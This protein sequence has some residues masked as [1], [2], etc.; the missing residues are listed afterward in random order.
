MTILASRSA[1][2]ASYL[3]LTALL[4]GT[5]ARP[6]NASQLS[7]QAP[8]PSPTPADLVLDGGRVQLTGEQ[9]F[10]RLVLRNRARVEIQPYS[11]SEQTGLL[12]I[13]ADSVSIDRTSAIVGDAAGYRGQAR[14]EG[15]GPGGGEGGLDSFDGGGGGAHGGA[16]GAGVLDGVGQPAARG[17]RAYGSDCSRDIERGSAGGAPGAADSPGDPGR[18]GHGG[19]GLAIL[20]D[21]VAISGTIQLDG[22]DGIVE[23]NDAGGGGA[24]GGLWIEARQLVFDGRVEANGGAGGVTD[25]GGGGGG[26][27]RVKIFYV[28]GSVERRGI[29][30]NGGRGDGNGYPNDGRRGSLCVEQ[31]TPTPTPLVSATPSVTASPTPRATSTPSATPTASARPSGTPTPSPTASPTPTATAS[32]TAEPRALYL[33]LLLRERCPKIEAAR[34]EIVLVI[35]ASTSMRGMTRGG[36]SKLRAAL[37]AASLPISMVGGR[38]RLALVSFN[39]EARVLSPLSA[40]REQL[41]TALETILSQPGSRLD[42]GIREAVRVLSSALPGSE[43]RIVALTD[44]LPSPSTPEDVRAAAREARSNGIRIDT[45]GLGPDVDAELLQDLAGDPARY[46]DAPDGEDLMAIFADMNWRPPPCGGL[47]TWPAH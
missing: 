3:L 32:P 12:M 24:G 28:D 33:P 27:G 45:I 9:V 44:G 15:E 39:D 4:I 40:E 37:D 5:I 47:S 29:R 30:V 20:A 16:G 13:R 25:D 2:R 14:R 46:H 10:G 8:T 38:S 36:R 1:V 11:G 43:Q 26:G 18:G 6:P 34:L 31:L 7:A 35:D 21:T 17:G 19:A 42:A 22:E 23:R 41:S